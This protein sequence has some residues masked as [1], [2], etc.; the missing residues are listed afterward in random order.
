MTKQVS[1][2]DFLT[3]AQIEKARDIYCKH[4]DSGHVASLIE[5]NVIQPNMAEINRKLGQEN[6]ARYLAYCCEYVFGQMQADRPP[7]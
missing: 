7:P 1:L 5:T 2:L 6:D 3:E 4:K